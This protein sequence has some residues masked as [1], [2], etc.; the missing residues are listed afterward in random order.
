MASFEE[1]N[2]NFFV[3]VIFRIFRHQ[4][5]GLDQGLDSLNT[6]ETNRIRIRIWIRWVRTRG[7][8]WGCGGR[9][10]GTREWSPRMRR[11][12]GGCQSCAVWWQWR[13]TPALCPPRGEIPQGPGWALYHR[14]GA[15]QR[16]Q[17]SDQSRDKRN[18]KQTL[19]LLYVWEPW[20]FPN[21]YWF[22]NNVF[23]EDLI[24]QDE[25]LFNI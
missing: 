9:D 24:F 17:A 5:M 6:P 2:I 21:E 10:G 14:C 13:P 11:W 16:Q 7:L 22:P 15:E 25:A 18:G 19:W 8:T 1:K 12:A 3:T 4:T 23:L 20:P